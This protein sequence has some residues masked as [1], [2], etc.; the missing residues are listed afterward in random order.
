MVD[1]GV[2]GVGFV[3]FG[4]SGNGGFILGDL[5]REIESVFG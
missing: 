4:R 5:F 2:D 3:S 1:E